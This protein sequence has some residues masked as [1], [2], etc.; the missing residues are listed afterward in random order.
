M[1]GGIWCNTVI[2]RSQAGAPGA[3]CGGAA[4]ALCRLDAARA[5][6]NMVQPSQTQ[7]AAPEVLSDGESN[8]LS[9]PSLAA[10]EFGWCL[11][12]CLLM[13]PSDVCGGRVWPRA[14]MPLLQVETLQG[15]QGSNPKARLVALWSITTW[16]ATSQG[17]GRCHCQLLSQWEHT[18]AFTLLPLTSKIYAEVDGL[19][20]II[21]L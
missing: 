12:T 17:P 11:G 3:V 6:S 20:H 9:L 8:A 18:A 4:G 19:G 15:L 10:A 21:L 7:A 16:T 1:L 2:Q 13:V 14:Q 5:F